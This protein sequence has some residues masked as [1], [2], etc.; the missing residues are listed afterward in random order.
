MRAAPVALAMDSPSPM[1][2]Y[3]KDMIVAI[4][5]M[6]HTLQP[7]SSLSGAQ[8]MLNMVIGT[9]DPSN[10]QMVSRAKPCTH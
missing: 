10:R 7:A 2:A 8:A 5:L 3:R 6:I 4:T 9:Q 1:V